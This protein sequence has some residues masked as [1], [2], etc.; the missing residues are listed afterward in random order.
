MKLQNIVNLH[1]KDTSELWTKEF[2]PVCMLKKSGL[3]YWNGSH[4]NGKQEYNSGIGGCFALG[5]LRLQNILVRGWGHAP[6]GNFR[7]SGIVSGVMLIHS[8]LIACLLATSNHPTQESMIL[9]A[10]LICHCHYSLVVITW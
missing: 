5:R 10:S 9:K 7:L 8:I 4:R 1:I 6:S 2:V 3:E